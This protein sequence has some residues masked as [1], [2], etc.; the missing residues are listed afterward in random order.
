MKISVIIPA[1]NEERTIKEM[2]SAYYDYLA[3]NYDEFELILVD[4]GSSDNTLEIAK[5]CTG[6]ICISYKNN[7]GKGYAVKRGFLRA[8]GDYIFFT[9]ADLSYE[10]QN[11]TQALELFR[12]TNSSGVVGI[13]K[14]KYKD[15]TFLRCMVSNIC[16]KVV[17]CII[18]TTLEDT[19]CGFKG[20]EKSTGKQIFSRSEIFDFGFDFEVIYL[21]RVLGKS[22]SAM[23]VSFCHRK[24]THVNLLKDGLAII[25]DLIYIKRRQINEYIQKTV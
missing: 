24:D 21:S 16:A 13:R 1:Y 15:Y 22:I 23:P 4:D 10:P 25:K 9:D 12:M 6:V 8:T 19:Q 14:N 7:R 5:K 3:Q 20:F 18:S 11:I 17:R 2:L